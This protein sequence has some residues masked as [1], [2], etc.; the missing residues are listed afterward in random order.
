MVE[1]LHR[2]GEV[3]RGAIDP[4][5]RQCAVQHLAG[6]SCKWLPTQIFGVTGLL[7]DQHHPRIGR[8]LPEHGL[9]G[10]LPQRALAAGAGLSAQIVQA[11]GFG[12]RCRRVRSQRNPALRC[13]RGTVMHFLHA[14]GGVAHQAWQQSGFRQVAPVLGRH[15]LHHHPRV[16]PGRIEDAGVV[17]LPQRLACILGRGILAPCTGAEGKRL[18]IPGDAARRREDG[19]AHAGE[20]A[21]EERRDP[22]DDV[23]LWLEPGDEC[24]RLARHFAEAHECLHLVRVAADRLCHGHRPQYVGIGRV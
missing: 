15:L 20:T 23:V 10:L 24:I 6:R 14:V 7:S 21:R 5:F 18:P 16:E 8:P 2:V 17:G 19:P 13:L 11:A 1:V 3:Q 12:C 4:Q 9:R 22:V